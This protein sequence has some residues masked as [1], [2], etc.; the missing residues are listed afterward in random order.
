MHPILK[1]VPWMSGLVN[2]LQNRLRR[3]E[4]A[5]HLTKT[6]SSAKGLPVFLLFIKILLIYVKNI[7]KRKFFRKFS[8]KMF[9]VSD[10]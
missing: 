5:R 9:V 1:L 3:F 8:D 10:F 7:T 4:S 6:G 2:G